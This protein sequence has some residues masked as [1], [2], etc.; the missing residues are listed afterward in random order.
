MSV[1][2]RSRRSRRALSWLG[3][4]AILGGL[5][6]V[7][8]YFDHPQLTNNPNPLV[9]LVYL[10]AGFILVGWGIRALLGDI[11]GAFRR[12][13][14]RSMN[15]HRVRMPRE[16]LIYFVILV[17]LCVGALIGH[18]NS[19]MLVFALMA[20]PFILS[21]QIASMV[22]RR[23]RVARGLPQYATAG[24]KFS[25]KVSMQNRKWLLSSWMVTVEDSLQ[26]PREQLQASVLFTRI[27]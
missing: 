17:V 27:P 2:P 13:D 9:V 12:P 26:T 8:S 14:T 23:L 19:L 21:S 18:S 20:G 6:L 11:A 4:V 7:W 16:A 10:G 15:R 25:V 24:E 3:L 1:R 5:A 22:L